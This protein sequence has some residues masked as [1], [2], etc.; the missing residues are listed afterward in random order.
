M[1]CSFKIA[2][3]V[4]AD[5]AV[6]Q[7]RHLCN[8]SAVVQLVLDL[9]TSKNTIL[10]SKDVEDGLT[11]VIVKS[12]L[13]GRR[14]KSIQLNFSSPGFVEQGSKQEDRW[15]ALEQKA[16]QQ[17]SRLG[18]NLQRRLDLDETQIRVDGDVHT[19]VDPNCD[20]H[21][22]GVA[23]ISFPEVSP[24]R[25]VCNTVLAKV[26]NSIVWTTLINAVVTIFCRM[27]S[28]TFFRTNLRFNTFTL[29]C[30]LSLTSFC[31]I[32]HHNLMSSNKVSKNS[33]ER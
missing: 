29:I 32:L 6:G 18:R 33:V 14:W 30:V 16:K 17:T 26:V 4:S 11:D 13:D 31:F 20:C 23:I 15:Y 1:S 19:D 8:D 25:N 9:G 28:T 21:Y 5:Q 2:A 10:D 12:W 24:Q 22:K 7:I 27:C 3:D